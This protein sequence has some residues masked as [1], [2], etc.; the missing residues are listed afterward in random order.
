MY[1][2]SLIIVIMIFKYHAKIFSTRYTVVVLEIVSQ[3]AIFIWVK[4]DQVRIQ[5]DVETSEVF[6]IIDNINIQL[7]PNWQPSTTKMDVAPMRF[8]ADSFRSVSY[9]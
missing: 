4:T 1:E 9:H 6:H 7:G 5:F 8:N 3:A 2:Y